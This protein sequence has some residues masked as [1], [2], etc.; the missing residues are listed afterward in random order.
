MRHVFRGYRKV[1]LLIGSTVLSLVPSFNID[2]GMQEQILYD[3][4]LGLLLLSVYL[5]FINGYLPTL[6]TTLSE[7]TKLAL[8][9]S[10]IV[11]IPLLTD[12]VFN[13]PDKSSNTLVTSV[14]SAAI[15]LVVR[16]LFVWWKEQDEIR[17]E[18]FSELYGNYR[19]LDSLVQF[20]LL[21]SQLGATFDE[22]WNKSVKP[23]WIEQSFNSHFRKLQAKR[24][25]SQD[26]I[27]DLRDIYE[28]V[29]LAINQID[30]HNN[31][32]SDSEFVNRNFLGD[33][34]LG[35]LGQI[36]ELLARLDNKKFGQL[37]TTDGEGKSQIRS[38]E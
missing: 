7:Q 14:L 11:C 10:V 36:R 29:R 21:Q 31:T 23:K 4:F 1:Y 18:I 37:F 16:E 12:F 9:S 26:T 8:H 25:Y 27:D 17:E 32:F 28:A 38:I 6:F 22:E 33:E 34:N 2:T 3:I 24:I 15:T 20:Y 19:S 13:H 35:V 30:N 5:N